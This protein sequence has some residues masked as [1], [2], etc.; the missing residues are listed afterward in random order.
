MKAEL[1]GDYLGR[2]FKEMGTLL[3]SKEAKTL[4]QEGESQ[5]RDTLHSQCQKRVGD[6]AEYTKQ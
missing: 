5:I 2:L 4:A 1:P 3:M 6:E